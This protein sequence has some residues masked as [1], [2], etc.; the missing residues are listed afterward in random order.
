MNF[1]TIK[2]NN[3]IF[4]RLNSLSRIY[5]RRVLQI[6]NIKSSL[7]SGL[8]II[9]YHI[10]FFI[11]SEIHIFFKAEKDVVSIFILI[12]FYKTTIQIHKFRT[13]MGIRQKAICVSFS[14][15]DWN[16]HTSLIIYTIHYTH[17]I[18]NYIFSLVLYPSCALTLCTFYRR[19]FNFLY[20]FLY[21]S[22]C[23]FKQNIQNFHDNN[24]T[25]CQSN[26]LLYFF[27]ERILREAPQ[28]LEEI[29]FFL[30]F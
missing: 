6:T 17:N 28:N 5:R 9:S 21:F 20:P 16:S 23:H 4:A 12:L 14:D 15:F 27:I 1:I 30:Y 24:D 18:E 2:N 7:K 26:F 11:A 25:M 8:D 29:R 22:F 10:I 13:V 3:K 19:K